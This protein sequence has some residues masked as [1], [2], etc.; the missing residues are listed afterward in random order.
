MQLNFGDISKSD[1][2]LVILGGGGIVMFTWKNS[3]KQP[4]SFLNNY[5]IT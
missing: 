1:E 3:G 4:L 5:L 2:Q